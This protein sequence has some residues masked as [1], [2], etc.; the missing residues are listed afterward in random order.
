MTQAHLADGTVLDFPDETSPEVIQRVVKQHIASQQPSAPDPRNPPQLPEGSQQGRHL[1][2]EQG[3]ALLDQQDANG[4][5][6]SYLTS[7]VSGIPIVGPALLGGEKRVAAGLSSLLNGKSYDDNLQRAQDI[8][9]AAQEDHPNLATAGQ[10]TGAVAPLVAIGGTSL[11]AQ[12]LGLERIGG[13]LPQAAAFGQKLA[14]LGS[15]ALASATS[16]AG[17]SAADTAARGGSG[18]DVVNNAT[19]SGLIGGAVPI[20]GSGIGAALSSAA[21][22]VAPV[23]GAL[24]NPVKEAARRIGGA[25]ERDAAAGANAITPADEAVARYSG[26][27]LTNA[28]RGG[29]VTRAMVRSVANQNPEARETLTAAADS[30]FSGQ[31]NR[32]INFVRKIF[33]GNVDDLQY[34]DALKKAADAANAPAYDAAWAHPNAQAV[35]TPRLQQLM[36]SPAFRSAVDAVP[37][38]SA[39]RGALAGQKALENPF[40]LNSQGDYVLRQTANGTRVNPTLRFWD[41]VKRN[42]DTKI[43]LAKRAGDDTYRDLTG[44]KQALVGELDSAVPIYKNARQGAAAFFGADDALE[45]GK[46]FAN[47]PRQIP[48]AQRAVDAMT[49]VEKQAFST[50]YASE[51]IDQLK[52]PGDRSNVIQMRFGTEAARQSNVIALGPQRAAAIEAYA[53]T[54]ALADKLRGALGNSTTARQLKEMGLGAGIGG[55]AGAWNGRDLGSTTLGAMLGAA[56]GK[57]GGMALEAANRQVFTHMAQLLTQDNPA[58]IAAA[59]QLATKNPAYMTALQ[60]MSDALGIGTRAA[61]VAGSELR[62]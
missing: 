10:I 28:D 11:G 3:A 44:L 22:R 26:I 2:Y 61:N 30:R 54:E 5:I 41:Q 19:V 12:A 16:N 60:R 58:A 53:R 45:A 6:G 34:Q 8:T 23:V 39:N 36:Q 52:V 14:S 1:T 24:F 35:Y 49:P 55:A 21:D 31:S 17:I 37:E 50:G 33:G 48:E 47:T 32:A 7:A 15:R 56:A 9:A 57:G 20:V 62:Q 40:S 46:K 27:P 38:T 43:G 4:G 59:R 51:L 42:L 29:E 25:F 13:A 18:S